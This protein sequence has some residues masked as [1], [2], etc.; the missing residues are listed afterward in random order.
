MRNVQNWVIKRSKRNYNGCR[1]QVNKDN[2]SNERQKAS[3]HFRNKKKKEKEKKRKLKDKINE[4]E[5]KSKN[6][7]IRDL[8]KG[9]NEFTKSY[10]PRTN[11]VWDESYLLVDPNI[12]NRW[13]NYFCQLLNAHGAGGVKQ[14]EMIQLSH[15]CQTLVLLRLRQHHCLVP[16]PPKEK[17]GL[18]F[19]VNRKLCKLHSQSKTLLLS[20][21][22]FTVSSICRKEL[23]GRNEARQQIFN[24]RIKAMPSQV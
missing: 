24:P 23:K 21:E 19:Q 4:L 10:H 20:E 9:I 2:L 15:L 3:K 11:L 8:Y 22:Y 12:L 1:T 5:S 14:T 6:M 17:K 16:F 7:N 13:K 18:L